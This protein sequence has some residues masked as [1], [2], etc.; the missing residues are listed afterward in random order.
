MPRHPAQPPVEPA[1]PYG[2]GDSSD[3]PSERPAGE[4]DA[5]SDAQGTGARPRAEPPYLAPDEDAPDIEPDREVDAAQ[6]GLAHT[7]PDP[8]RNGGG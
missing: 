1:D 2:P 5:A 3:M 4:T 6:A 7:R 8:A